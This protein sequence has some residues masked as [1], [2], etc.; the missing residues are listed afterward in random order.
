MEEKM[1]MLYKK[2]ILQHNDHPVA[3]EEREDA[4]F[5]IEAYNPLC[6]DRF[7]LYLNFENSRVKNV[8]FYGYGCAISKASTSVL[9]KKIR[10]LTR[11]EV[12]LLFDSFYEIVSPGAQ[13]NG[14]TQDEELEAFGGARHFP[15]RLKCATLSWDSLKEFMERQE[16][17]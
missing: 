2:V 17:V 6:G 3:Y 12:A 16:S 1:R 8:W 13:N 4:Q 14:A 5:S 15:G 7:K 10:G 11:A 9:V